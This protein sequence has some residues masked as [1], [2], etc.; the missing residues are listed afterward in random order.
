[1]DPPGQLLGVKPRRVHGVSDLHSSLDKAG[2]CLLRVPVRGW[3]HH[4]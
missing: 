2:L 1:M 4:F 3:Q